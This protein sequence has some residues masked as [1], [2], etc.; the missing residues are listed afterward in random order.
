MERF[1]LQ[2]EAAKSIEREGKKSRGRKDKGG[3]GGGKQGGGGKEKKSKK[4]PGRSSSRGGGDEDE[5]EAA[6]DSGDES[7]CVSP[8]A[9]SF[10]PFHCRSTALSTALST[11]PNQH[12]PPGA[13]C[14]LV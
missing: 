7:G 12:I 8:S 4:K 3:G 10:V 2:V 13:L 9:G 1:L 14:E 11:S 5:E 6:E